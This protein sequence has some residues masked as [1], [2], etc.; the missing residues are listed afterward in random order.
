MNQKK[1]I[2]NIGTAEI[3]RELN[4]PFNTQENGKQNCRI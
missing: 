1:A 3:D 4:T 2:D